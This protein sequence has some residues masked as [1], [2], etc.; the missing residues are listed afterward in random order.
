MCRFSKFRLNK[1]LCKW[2]LGILWWVD[3]DL[4]ISLYTKQCIVVL[5]KHRDGQVFFYI[6][7]HKNL[8]NFLFFV[9]ITGFVSIAYNYDL[10]IYNIIFVTTGRVWIGASKVT[11]S[12]EWMWVNTMAK[13]INGYTKWANGEPSGDGD[14]AYINVHGEWN[15]ANCNNTL[16]Y[17]CDIP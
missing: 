12:I 5:P 16:L 17:A 7:K 6:S 8:S 14:C 3:N 2:I 13:P 15:D 1:I 4:G 9:N 11:S 10:I